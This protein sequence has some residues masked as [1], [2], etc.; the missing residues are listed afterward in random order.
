MLAIVM[1]AMVTATPHAKAPNLAVEWPRATVRGL[2]EVARVGLAAPDVE[3]ARVPDGGI[4]PQAVAG[5]DGTIH[6]LYYKGDPGGGD[7]FYVRRLSTETRW[8][9]PRGVNSEPGSAVAIGNVRGG[10]LALGRDNTVHVAWNGSGVA[11]AESPHGSAMLYTRLA[12][13]AEDFEPQRNLMTTSAV[14]DGGGSVAADADGNVYVVW[15]ALPIDASD[16]AETG[17]RVFVAASSDDGATFAAEEARSDASNGACGCCGLKAGTLPDG[18]LLVLYRA[19]GRSVN[20]DMHLMRST[21]RGHT[22]LD[23]RIDQWSVNT[24]PMTTASIAPAGTT[25]VLTWETRENIRW[26]LVA[27]GAASPDAIRTA[28]PPGSVLDKHSVAAMDGDGRVLVAWT[29]G[30]RWNTGGTLRWAIFGPDGTPVEGAEGTTSGVPVWS[31]VAVV[32]KPGRGFLI[33]Y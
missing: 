10:Q 29:E 22:F 7:L 32:A 18:D 25:A 31:L 21:D 1:C 4:Q 17:R 26:G 12:A 6:L 11:A 19:A 23:T 20:R 13:G 33:L 3:T 14:L 24:C 8:S 2:D 5:D 16:R 27:D 30:M 28:S 9:E 15:H